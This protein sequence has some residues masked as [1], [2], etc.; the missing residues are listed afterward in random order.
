MLGA[1]AVTCFFQKALAINY[2]IVNPVSGCAYFPSTNNDGATSQYAIAGSTTYLDDDNL[3]DSNEAFIK[4]LQ[5]KNLIPT[6]NTFV[7]GFYETAI[8]GECKVTYPQLLLRMFG[9]IANTTLE[10]GFLAAM[11]EFCKIKTDEVDEEN[12]KFMLT[13]ELLLGVVGGITLLT[14]LISLICWGVFRHI[15]GANRRHRADEGANRR[16]RADGE[17]NPLLLANDTATVAPV[18]DLETGK[19]NRI[20]DKVPEDESHNDKKTGGY[21]AFAKN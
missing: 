11:K 3:Y 18:A 5:D 9:E 21:Q 1:L 16:H 13:A 20:T 8:T 15:E 4:I 12:A 19:A 6:N 7:P 17:R 2:A 10:D 14:C